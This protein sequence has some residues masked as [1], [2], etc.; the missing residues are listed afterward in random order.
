M[1]NLTNR[2]FSR[3]VTVFDVSH[4]LPSRQWLGRPLYCIDT[5]SATNLFGSIKPYTAP[6]KCYGR[7]VGNQCPINEI[8]NQLRRSKNKGAVYSGYATRS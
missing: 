1:T 2:I 5:K 8:I 6:H 7:L 3:A 4:S